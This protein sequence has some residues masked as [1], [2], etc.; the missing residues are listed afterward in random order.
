MAL[1]I[2]YAFFGLVW[3]LV[4]PTYFTRRM[5][6]RD[7]E[8]PAGRMGLALVAVLVLLP[9]ATFGLASILRQPMNEVMI[10]VVATAWNI[11]GTLHQ[12]AA[13]RRR[14]RQG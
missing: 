9:I 11:V 6:L 7:I 8:S 5:F 13:Y 12:G 1:N 14:I 10:F 4:L 2:L 3:V